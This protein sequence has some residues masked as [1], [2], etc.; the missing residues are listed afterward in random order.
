MLIIADVQVT[1]K[2]SMAEGHTTALLP[3]SGDNGAWGRGA[4]GTC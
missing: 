4:V 1:R 3:R 2:P